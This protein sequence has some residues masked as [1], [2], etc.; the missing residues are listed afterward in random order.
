M[1]PGSLQSLAIAPALVLLPSRMSSREARV[2]LT[3]IALQES[4]LRHRHQVNGPAHGLWQF[5]EKGGTACVLSH[6]AASPYA[7]PI[8]IQL[9]YDPEDLHGVY[10]G[11]EHN[12]VLACVFARLLLWTVP[13]PLPQTMEDGW[14]Q[15][16]IAWRPG[17]P[18]FKT[19]PHRWS[20]AQEVVQ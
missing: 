7:R 20:Q 10:L 11:L 5:E 12:D 14:Q 15:Y 1:T 9:L 19:W 8:C 13:E 3:A 6:R 4:G 17:R 18:H 2:M 16:L